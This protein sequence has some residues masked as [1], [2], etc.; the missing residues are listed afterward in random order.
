MFFAWDITVLAGT[1]EAAPKKQTL[2]LS[3]GV[4]TEASIKFPSGC[5]GLVKV[6]LMHGE[7]QL[8]PLSRAE[9]I[10]GDDEAVKMAAYFELAPGA[11]KLKFEGCSPGTTYGHTVSVRITV[12]P[13]A[14][15]SLVP[16]VNV[17]T[18]FLRRVGV[19][20]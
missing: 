17:L 7:F 3:S 2:S 14:V 9:W 11:S 8:L 6:R 10:T 1:T 5:H 15:A 18:A 20:R 19:I 16:L 13:K 12:L 4:I